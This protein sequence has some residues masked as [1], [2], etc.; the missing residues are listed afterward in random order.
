MGIGS[1]IQS[2][3]RIRDVAR[4]PA[5]ASKLSGLSLMRPPLRLG[6]VGDEFGVA[7]GVEEAVAEEF[8]GKVEAGPEGVLVRETPPCGLPTLWPRLR[9]T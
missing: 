6:E 8:D 3:G 5:F 2:D 4:A 9:P 7:L 1:G